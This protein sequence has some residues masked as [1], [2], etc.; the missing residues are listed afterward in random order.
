MLESYVVG[1]KKKI[2]QSKGH[3]SAWVGLPFSIVK[4]ALINKVNI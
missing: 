2:A 4:A 1:K 3:W